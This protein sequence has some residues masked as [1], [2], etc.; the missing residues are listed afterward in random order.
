MRATLYFSL[1]QASLLDTNLISHCILK[2][3]KIPFWKRKAIDSIMLKHTF[4]EERDL[5]NIYLKAHFLLYDSLWE[6]IGYILNIPQE[7]FAKFYGLGPYTT[8]TNLLYKIRYLYFLNCL[9]VIIID[10]IVKTLSKF[11][12]RM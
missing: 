5:R 2:Q 9:F 8:Q 7:Q 4:S 6:P 12:K 11:F 1:A 10:R 3:F